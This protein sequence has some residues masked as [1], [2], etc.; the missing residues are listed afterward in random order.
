MSNAELTCEN[1][2]HLELESFIDRPNHRLLR[3]PECN[4]MQK[5]ILESA[6]VYEGDYHSNYSGR[7]KA[8]IVTGLIR[9]ASTTR[10]LETEKPKTLDIGCSVGATV[11]AAKEL[12]WDAHGVD[13]SER[14]VEYC[15][16]LGLN[17]ETI[18]GVELPY[19]DGTFDLVTNWHVIE[20]VLDV[21]ETIQEWKRV[22]KPGGI[23]ILETPASNYLKARIMGPRY[24]KFWPPDHLYT[25]DRSNLTSLLRTGG[26]EILPSRLIGKVNALPAHLS[27][28]ALAYRG[29]RETCRAVNMCKSIEICCR[30]PNAAATV[31]RAA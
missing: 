8:K 21:T 1:C 28:Y 27:A 12:G 7:R 10:Y 29:F 9:L 26:F 17:C 24:K 15:Q 14:A 18:A 22:L 31:R 13:I 6:S 11:Q 2:G 19:E 4:L 20:H 25:F 5:G 16:S 23:M 3:C 30:K